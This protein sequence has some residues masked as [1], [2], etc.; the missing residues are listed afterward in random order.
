VNNAYG[1]RQDLRR[2]TGIARF[3][4]GHDHL[5]PH[6]PRIRPEIVDLFGLNQSR[7]GQ[8]AAVQLKE[9]EDLKKRLRVMINK[10]SQRSID[11]ECRPATDAPC[12]MAR[13][14]DP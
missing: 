3:V 11:Q 5:S 8:S 1:S 7:S 6:I 12:P 13:T 14:S 2:L 9:E 10:Y 4:H